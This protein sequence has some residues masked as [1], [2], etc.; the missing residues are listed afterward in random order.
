[1]TQQKFFEYDG[2]HGT[3]KQQLQFLIPTT[4]IRGGQPH[5]SR[6]GREGRP[7]GQIERGSFVQKH[8]DLGRFRY[9]G[10]GAMLLLM[11]LLKFLIDIQGNDRGHLFRRRGGGRHGPFQQNGRDGVEVQRPQ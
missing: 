3:V 1:M 4:T 6:Q 5:E 2:I 8:G 10:G 9:L 7:Q 11:V